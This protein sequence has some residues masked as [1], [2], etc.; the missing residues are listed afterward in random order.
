MFREIKIEVINISF[1]TNFYSDQFHEF[2]SFEENIN[3]VS[4]IYH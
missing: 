4:I 1:L 2:L 3:F